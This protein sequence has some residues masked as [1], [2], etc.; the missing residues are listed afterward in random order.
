MTNNENVIPLVSVGIPVYNDEKFIK[1]A[2]ES[3]LNQTF[4]NFELI[5]SDNASTDSTSNICEEFVKKDNRIK[6]I[7]QDQNINLLPNYNF[8]LEKAE[9]KYFVWLEADDFWYPQF[10]ERN[11]KILESNHEFVASAGNIEYYGEEIDNKNNKEESKFRKYIKNKQYLDPKFKYIH[12]ISGT[13]EEKINFYLRFNRGSGIYA[14]YRTNI[15]KKSSIKKP[16]AAWDL[17]IILNALRYGDLHVFEETMMK[18]Y[19]LGTSS[20]GLIAEY[21]NKQISLA[22][23]IIPNST[24]A[25][26]A[27]KNLGWKIFLKNIDWFFL[28]TC[29]GW[30]TILFESFKK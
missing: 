21:R 22:D 28:L 12:P 8:V 25:I 7:K 16:V 17:I 2:I 27:I 5:I 30:R 9:S 23:I 20:K 29:Y 26:W 24:F 19:S 13:F 6:Y 14:V 15:I 4:T 18:R 10:L 1:K 11:I 3:V